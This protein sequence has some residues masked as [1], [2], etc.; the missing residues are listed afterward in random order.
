M[1]GFTS[2]RILRPDLFYNFNRY[3]K[4][5]CDPIPTPFGINW[6]GA[7]YTKELHFILQ[8]MMIRRL[9]KDVLNELPPK[10]RSKIEI[11]ADKKFFYSI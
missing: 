4:R 1:E 11:E 3:G 2:L 9:K 10:R 6:S 5:Y 7:S 8:T